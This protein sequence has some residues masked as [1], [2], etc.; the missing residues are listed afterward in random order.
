[1]KSFLFF[2]LLATKVLAFESYG[3]GKIVKV[4]KKDAVGFGNIQYFLVVK[5][6]EQVGAM[7]IIF[8]DKIAEKDVVNKIDQIV[9]FRG[10]IK[11]QKFK[12][13]ERVETVDV[14]DFVKLK[15]LTFKDLNDNIAEI[16][17]KDPS[18]NLR[19]QPKKNRFVLSD[20]V[21]QKAILTSAALLLNDM[22]ATDRP[23]GKFDRDLTAGVLLTSGI[24]MMADKIKKMVKVEQDDWHLPDNQ[25]AEKEERKLPLTNQD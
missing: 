22:A 8:N 23:Q 4:S 10:K 14:V 6:G 12:Q 3:I 13:K 1:M 19:V 17:K 18:F 21:A 15:K 20:D 5:Q 16:N 9:I 25:A 11:S 2:M 7:P 24:I